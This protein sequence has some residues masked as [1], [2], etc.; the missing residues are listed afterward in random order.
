[1]F[2]V[3]QFDR[4]MTIRADEEQKQEKAKRVRRMILRN[5]ERFSDEHERRLKISK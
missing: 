3:N 2:N 4:L 1:M 5:R